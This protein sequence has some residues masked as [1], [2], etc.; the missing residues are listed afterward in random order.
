MSSRIRSLLDIITCWIWTCVFRMKLLIGGHEFGC[1]IKSSGP[2]NLICKGNGKVIIGERC[3]FHSG[4]RVNPVGSSEKMMIWISKGAE[5][6]IG[7][8]SGLSNTTV[9]ATV[10]VKIG[11]RCKIGGGTRIYDTDFHSLNPLNRAAV[12]DP[13]VVRKPIVIGDDVFI[14]GHVIILKG[15]EVGD[16]AV[17]GA[18]SVVTKNVP[19]G[20]I[21]A[22]NPAKCL[23]KI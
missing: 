13:D 17:I 7:S 18:G 23:R 2:I 1:P 22:G 6:H 5:L 21:W 19:A 14:G 10:G 3:V 9:V 8:D 15:V 4:H 20:E 12:P 16:G 11:K